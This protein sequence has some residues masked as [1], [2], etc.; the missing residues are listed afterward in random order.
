MEF[1]KDKAKSLYMLKDSVVVILRCIAFNF[2]Y[3]VY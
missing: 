2:R 1:I 3:S